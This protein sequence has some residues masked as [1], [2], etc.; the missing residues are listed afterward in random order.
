MLRKN[1]STDDGLVNG[2]CGTITGFRWSQGNSSTAQPD[3]IETKFDNEDVGKQSRGHDDEGTEPGS[4]VIH[5][6]TARFQSTNGR[7]TL[8]LPISPRIGMVHHHS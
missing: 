5:T 8:E 3:G 4:T 1:V 7:H 2:A 6:M